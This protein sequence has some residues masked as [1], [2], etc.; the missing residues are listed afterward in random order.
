VDF[1]FVLSAFLITLKQTDLTIETDN[2][3]KKLFTGRLVR[4]LLPYIVLALFYN[5][6][7]F[8]IFYNRRVNLFEYFVSLSL[9]QI[10]GVNLGGAFNDVNVLGVSWA[11]GLELYVGT[12][13]FP[14]VFHLKKKYSGIL[15]FICI[16]IFIISIGVLRQFS[17]DFFNIH[18]WRYTEI[19][20][21]IFRII[22]SYS[23]GTLCAILYKKIEKF[24]FNKYKFLIFN[25][26][27]VFSLI[28]LVKIYGSINYN[29][30]NDFIFP[31]IIGL[32]ITIFSYEI[33][34][35]SKILRKVSKL[36][37]L[38]YSI[39]LIHPFFIQIFKY[40]GL[41]NIYFYLGIVVLVSF[42]FYYF[43]E[44]RIIDLKYYLLSKAYI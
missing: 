3:L 16:M 38:G 43:I 25:I 35:I 10:L 34:F 7:L 37:K 17:P 1:F 28:M 22:I 26:F 12:I 21:G 14:I 5:V 20:F 8:K 33:G 24:Q 27:E 32:I 31:I 11:L 4:L 19:P 39:Y 6:F 41:S 13:F 44:K 2:Y 9:I 40:K 23:I 15:S 18:Y 29:R 42:L 36:G 30:Q